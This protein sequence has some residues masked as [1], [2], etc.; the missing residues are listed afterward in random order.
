MINN[1]PEILAPAGSVAA[2]RGALSAGADAVYIGGTRFSARA[3]ADNAEASEL[4]DA[5][6][7]AHLNGK[8][9]YMTINTLFKEKELTGELY[10]FLVPYYEKGLDAAI[11]QDFGLLK[12]LKNLFPNLPVH[13]STQMT[14]ASG[15]GAR[16]LESYG[17]VTRIVPARELSLSEIR[18]LRA[19]TGLE[20]ECFVHGALCYSYSGQCLF[21]SM[22][23][24]RSGNRGRCAQPCR[25]PYELFDRDKKI[26]SG[27]L[28][29]LKDMCS[30]ASIP[31]LIDAG[32]DSFKIEGRM[33]RPEYSAGIAALYN[34]LSEK[35]VSLGRD[36]YERFLQDNPEIIK[37]VMTEAADLYNRGGFSK[38]YYFNYHGP[39]MMSPERPNHSGVQVGT[40]ANVAKRLISIRMSEK[41]HPQDVVEIRGQVPF[42]FTLGKEGVKKMEAAGDRLYEVVVGPEAKIRKNDPVFR[43]KNDFLLSDIKARYLDTVAKGKVNGFLSAFCGTPVTLTVS[44]GNASFTAMGSEVQTAQKAPMSVDDLARTLKKTGEDIFDFSELHIECG[45]NVFVAVSS[46]KEVRRVAFLGLA[47]EVKKMYERKAS[48]DKAIANDFFRSEKEAYAIK[49]VTKTLTVSVSNLLQ[50]NEVMQEEAV[51]TVILDLR[52]LSLSQQ[53]E[54]TRKVREA[55]KT[56]YLSMPHIFRNRE[57]ETFLREFDFEKPVNLL[58]HSLDEIMF[59]KEHGLEKYTKAS[60]ALYVTNTAAAGFL[61]E[62]GIKDMSLS[63]ELTQ[64]EMMDLD[65]TDGELLVYGRTPLMYTAQCLLDNF[66]SCLKKGVGERGFYY[67]KDKTGAEFPVMP[68]CRECMNVIYNSK[69]TCLIDCEELEEITANSHL[70]SFTTEAQ[71]EVKKV[72]WAYKNNDA[73][74]LYGLTRGHLRNGVE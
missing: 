24:G 47:E 9:V 44:F 18:A 39:L 35:Y 38:G 32:I 65:M 46:L 25:Q 10:D 13:G 12:T 22:I 74:G 63:L 71:E 23:G 43:T 34:M 70:I 41:V 19:E 50:L 69:T 48:N 58:I 51:D 6:D 72:L 37:D 15:A 30:L 5:I 56:A 28:L 17:N 8:K 4:L 1:K 66:S 42:E 54:E 14:V 57:K 68:M 60:N 26:A 64:R 31:D 11:V 21:S 2:L 45:D 20:I 61:R 3:Y 27:Y 52:L 62:M 7:F 73:A 67:I 29:S 36:K 55:G 59:I 53:I 49:P 16:L 40:V 33:K